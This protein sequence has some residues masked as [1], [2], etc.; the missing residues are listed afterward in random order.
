LSRRP[1]GPRRRRFGDFGER[2][3]ASHLESKGFTILEKNWSVREGE[4]DIVASKGTD[5]VFVEVRSRQG[6]NFG[7]PEESI[8]GRKA[9]HV[10]AAAAAYIQQHPDAP[11]NPRI[12]VV[13]LEL[14]AKGRVLR[15]EQI[16]NAIEDEGDPSGAD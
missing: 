2:V 12:D 1:S 16:E 8:T 15:V 6:R 14:D 4:I 7:T 10:R 13:V 11:P 3:A 5:L 9:A